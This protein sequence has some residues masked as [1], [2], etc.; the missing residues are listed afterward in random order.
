MNRE[1]LD[2][3]EIEQ[4]RQAAGRAAAPRG[5]RAELHTVAPLAVMSRAQPLFMYIP[6][7]CMSSKPRA[8]A[9]GWFLQAA[10]HTI[11]TVG[12]ALAQNRVE[13]IQFMLPMSWELKAGS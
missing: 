7:Y 6:H 9:H 12:K 2:M 11:A 1:S 4:V 10:D 5:S 8:V 3:K 13:T